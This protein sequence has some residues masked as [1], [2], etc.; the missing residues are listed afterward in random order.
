MSTG[1]SERFDPGHGRVMREWVAVG[2]EKDAWVPLAREA[3]DFVKRGR[4][5]DCRERE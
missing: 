1:E 5:P 4:P 2:L 3:Y